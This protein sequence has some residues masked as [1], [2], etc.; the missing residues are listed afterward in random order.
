MRRQHVL[1]GTDAPLLDSTREYDPT[2]FLT[3]SHRK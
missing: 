3:H 1:N 2:A